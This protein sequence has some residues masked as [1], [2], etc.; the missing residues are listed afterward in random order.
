MLLKNTGRVFSKHTELQKQ[1]VLNNCLWSVRRQL[2]PKLMQLC[3]KHAILILKQ[4]QQCF[5]H[6]TDLFQDMNGLLT[7]VFAQTRENKS[8]ISYFCFNLNEKYN[9]RIVAQLWMRPNDIKNFHKISHCKFG[10][11]ILK[12]DFSLLTSLTDLLP[13][14]S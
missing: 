13:I 12:T 5:D 3:C 9:C 4:T 6:T 8:I 10:K 14:W 2:H 7:G 1:L 11:I